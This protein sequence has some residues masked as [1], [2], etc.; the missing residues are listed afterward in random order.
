MDE[1]T[2]LSIRAGG[3][4]AICTTYWLRPGLERWLI[5]MSASD[6]VLGLISMFPDSRLLPVTSLISIKGAGDIG[7]LMRCVLSNTS[8]SKNIIIMTSDVEWGRSWGFTDIGQAGN[9][10]MMMLNNY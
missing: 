8:D 4:V 10:I 1:Q 5:D 9:K 6:E 2:R 7:E 3:C